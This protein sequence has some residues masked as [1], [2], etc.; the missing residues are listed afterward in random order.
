MLQQAL[1]RPHLDTEIDAAAYFREICNAIRQS[2]L[3]DTGIELSFHDR[4]MPM[5]A[6]LCWRLGIIASE[7]ISNAARHA[8]ESGRGLI[9]VEL[10]LSPDGLECRVTDSGR[11]SMEIP[12]GPR[13]QHRQCSHQAV[14]G[15]MHHYS[16]GTGTMWI[17]TV[18]C[19]SFTAAASD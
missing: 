10:F 5:R 19:E 18:P 4:L 9:R 14:N 3:A 16:D 11:G 2:K 17:V 8:F 6:T 7:L 12:P 15:R 1:Q 13:P